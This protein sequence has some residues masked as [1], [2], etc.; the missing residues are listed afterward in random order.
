M[1]QRV[2][3]VVA[4]SAGAP[5]E[6]VPVLVPDPGPGEALV[7]VRAC[8]VCHTDLHFR[9]GAMRGEFPFLLG[10]EA[11]GVVEAVGPDVADPLPGDHV[12]LAWRC[13][14]AAGSATPPSTPP[15]SWVPAR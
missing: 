9:Q 1:G 2:L 6:V 5:V 10:H 15:R 4:G 12:V 14:A 8:G 3:G 11:V 13:S 7:R